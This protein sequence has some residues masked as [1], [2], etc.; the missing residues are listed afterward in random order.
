MEKFLKD[1]SKFQ[2]IALKDDNFW[3]FVTSKQKPINKSYKKLVDSNSMSEETQKHLK[4]VGSR[5]RIMYC[6]CKV[7]NKCVKS[8]SP[9]RPILSALKT[10][11]H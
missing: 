5:P 2:K 10:P 4:P 8:C 9:F 11:A 3:N 6:F 1:Q 7:H